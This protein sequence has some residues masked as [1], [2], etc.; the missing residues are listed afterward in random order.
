MNSV[1]TNKTV[2]ANRADNSL[3][4]MAIWR[5][6]IPQG[7][8]KASPHASADAAGTY[9]DGTLN[10]VPGSYSGI[11]WSEVVVYL[12]SCRHELRLA[13][14]KRSRRVFVLQAADRGGAP[15]TYVDG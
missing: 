1:S 12:S 6:P 10:P 13:S 8:S 15:W 5:P 14:C 11:S 2:P 9:P 7:T 3:T 4:D